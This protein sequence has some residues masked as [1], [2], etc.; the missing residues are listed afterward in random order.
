VTSL[1]ESLPAPSEVPIVIQIHDSIASQETFISSMADKLHSLLLHFDQ[2][3]EALKDCEAG[4]AFG[5]D[6]LSGES[7]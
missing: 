5:E 4:V 2:M 1:R 6:D 3:A 7:I